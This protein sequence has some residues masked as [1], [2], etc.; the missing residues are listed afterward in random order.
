MDK[1]I[2]KRLDGRYEITELIG[3]GGMADVYKAVDTVNDKVVAVKILKKEFA[4]NDD[5]VR[6]FRNESKAIAVLSHPNIVKIYDVGFTDKMQFIVMEY[7]DGITLKEFMEQQGILKWKDA[8]Y[9]INQILRALQH[10]HDRG[11]VHRDIKPQNIMLFPDG[12]IKVMDFGIARFAREEGKTLSDKAIGSVHYISP[13]QAKGDVTDERSDI[14]S[15]GIM[16]YEMLTGQKPFDAD[17]PVAVAVM[18]MQNTARPPREIND[19]I[20]AGLE[21]IVMRAMQKDPAM[22]YQSASEMINDI[23]EF[24]KNP[25]V[26][27]GYNF[28]QTAY[29]GSAVSA[30]I[31]DN[32]TEKTQYFSKSEVRS[33]SL[34]TKY[35]NDPYASESN[36]SRPVKKPRYDDDDDEDDDEAISKSS[37]FVVTLT[38]IAATVVIAA[39]IFIAINVI[40]IITKTDVNT[41]IMPNLKGVNYTDAK[42]TYAQYFNLTV[43]SREYSS[44]Y[45][46]G[47]I[48]EQDYRAGDQFIIQNTDVSVIVS[49]G[50]QM[51]TVKNVY[52][53][54]ANEATDILTKQGFFVSIAF[55]TSDVEENHV[56]KTEPAQ[57]DQVEHGSTIIMYVSQGP[58]IQD[59]LM[60]DVVSMGL[61]AEDAEQLLAS[62][63]LKVKIEEEDSFEEK[64]LVLR[65]SV[66]ATDEYG[67]TMVVT[68]GTEVVLTVSS[69]VPPATEANIT[70]AVPSDTEGA[71]GFK[72][73]INGNIAGTTSIDNLAYV[74][75]VTVTVKG[76]LT[77]TV[78]IE[79]TNSDTGE[80]EKIGEYV[81]NFSNGTVTE[82][83]MNK[84]TFSKLFEKPEETTVT[85][86]E[87]GHGN[88][89]DIIDS[90]L[91]GDDEDQEGDEDEEDIPTVTTGDIY[92]DDETE[93]WWQTFTDND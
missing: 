83:S 43:K 23:E 81:V 63:G 25:S 19:A 57:S 35:N 92:P 33:T 67:D 39:V 21:E 76:S 87:N 12:G 47:V 69:G 13:E 36:K 34:K 9:F 22:R 40:P 3:M 15:T 7:I 73:Y 49:R 74:S 14:Y 2:G 24:R 62:K 31:P 91:G 38:A 27:F 10:A 88:I 42:Q 93:P 46:E 51:V 61:Y 82:M 11:I 79:A 72:A 26:T 8:V 4:D 59:V 48:I 55:Q 89:T 41:D 70:F 1:N 50:P 80:S 30:V 58:E 17:S 18:H 60:V 85:E 45:N 53:L 77:Q 64:G 6:R 84:E 86:D 75:T 65:Q 71:A 28:G 16:L 66:P 68:N 54:E 20:P 56:I 52:D 37:Y 78:N 5:F 44:E 32:E 90:I 29:K